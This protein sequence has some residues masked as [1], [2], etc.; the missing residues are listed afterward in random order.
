MVL[1]NVTI[2]IDVSVKDK[3][4][5]W[6]RTSHIPEVMAT[7]CFTESRISRVHGEEENGDTYAVTYLCPS[8]EMYDHYQSVHAPALQRQT[9]ELFSGKFAAFRTLLSVVEQFDAV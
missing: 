1:Y 2:S 7:G 3:W 4:L 6:M 8:M 5:N 9:V